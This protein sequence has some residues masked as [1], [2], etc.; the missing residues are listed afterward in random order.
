MGQNLSNSDFRRVAIKTAISE[1][2]YERALHLCLDGENK[3]SNYAG[4]VR[5]WKQQRY[6]IYEKTKDI[7]AQKSLCME[8][9][10]EGNFDFFSKLK[11][12]Y[13]NDEWACV[14]QDIIKDLEDSKQNSVYVSILIHEGLKSRLL[15]YCKKYVSAIDSYYEHLL[16]E[17]K[18][19]IGLLFVEYIRK[20]AAVANSR[21]NYRDVCDLIR[22]YKK[23][24]GEVANRIS[25]ELT[26]IYV[27]RPAF[28][29]ELR[30]I[31]GDAK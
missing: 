18:N 25:D 22:H 11:A 15:D 10:L 28:V 27:K 30:K 3:D 16:P 19:E 24:C 7:S 5:E 13:T 23:A 20:R 31:R 29:D 4:L 17:Y 1:G 26:A 9:V 21:N 12:L 14:L 8:F 6:I 2:L